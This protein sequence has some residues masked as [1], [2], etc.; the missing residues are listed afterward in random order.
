MTTNK[1]IEF[2]YKYIKNRSNLETMLGGVIVLL[3]IILT[4]KVVGHVAALLVIVYFFACSFLILIGNWFASPKRT[5]K[6]VLYQGSLD[7]LVKEFARLD[8]EPSSK[9]GNTYSFKTKSYFG[10]SLT[11]F[12]RDMGEG[13]ELYST[14]LSVIC[15]LDKANN[16]SKTKIIEVER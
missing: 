3:L 6:E 11:I 16:L 7:E 1:G 13:C 2:E 15:K 4:T 8:I 12:A 14:D 5:L 9:V 10:L